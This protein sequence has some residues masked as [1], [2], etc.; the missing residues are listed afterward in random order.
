M[1]DMHDQIDR[2][3]A[4]S[5]VPEDV[6][7][8]EPMSSDPHPDRTREN[9]RTSFSRMRGSW[10]GDD[11]RMLMEMEALAE[12]IVR[13][14]F[15]V[16]FG[17]RSRVHAHVRTQA[18]NESTGE[19][20]TYEDG[21]PVW[22]TDEWGVPVEDWG[23]LADRDRLSLLG[24]IATHMF[25]WEIAKANTWFEA[26]VAKGQ[27]EEIFSRGYTAL[28]GHVVSGKPTIE[29]RTHHSQKNAAK[30]R[31]F[32]LFESYISR[33][34]DG[35]VSSVKGLQRVLENTQPR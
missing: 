33:M 20:L 2:K 16:I 10:D 13:R 28:P 27:W 15:A 30:E 35:L 23:M 26:M 6:T 32:A 31:Y 18:H 7:T 24:V 14:R 22:V 8:E 3:L 29:D 5:D 34:A 9:A 25:E 21:T 11:A 19:Y 12:K 1:S 4:E 17:V